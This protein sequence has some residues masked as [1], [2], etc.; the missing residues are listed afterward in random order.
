MDV[1]KALVAMHA[2]SKVFQPSGA[3]TSMRKNL[4]ALPG[5]ASV[6]FKVFYGFMARLGFP[7]LLFIVGSSKIN[8]FI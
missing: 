3:H 8:C 4:S 1:V 5:N 2:F 7:Q 6:A